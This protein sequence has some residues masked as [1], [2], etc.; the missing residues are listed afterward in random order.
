ME[1]DFIVS[2]LLSE[3]KEE[4]AR[5]DSQ[6]QRA[7]KTL[8]ATILAALLAILVVVG[9]FLW[10]LNLYDFTSSETITTTSNATGVYALID[11][12]GNVIASDLTS[13]DIDKLVEVINGQ[14][15]SDSDS[16][17]NSDSNQD[18]N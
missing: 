2:E 1:P 5:K 17:Q 11:S 18:Q 8:F 16:N 13:E 3:L 10:Y 6:L 9:A 15:D 7:H 4:N 12:E 14:S